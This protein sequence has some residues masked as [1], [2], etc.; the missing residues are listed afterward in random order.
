MQWKR[1]KQ[2]GTISVM[3]TYGY[4]DERSTQYIHNIY[5]YIQIRIL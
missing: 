1:K 4:N 2:S 5:I 3:V